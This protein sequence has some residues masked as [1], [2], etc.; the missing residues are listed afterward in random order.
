MDIS[1]NSPSKASKVIVDWVWYEG[2]DALFEGEAVCFNT[3]YGTATARDGRRHNR[4]ERPSQGNNRAFAGVVARNYSAKTNGQFIEIN[5]PGSRGV[6]VALGVDTVIN[7]GFL[8]FQ[9]GGGTGAGRFVKA[10]LRGR[11]SIVP[12]QTKTAV[13]EA[14]MTGA[15]SL[16]TDGKTL[17]VVATAG[18][19]AGDT[20][21]FLGGEIE[22]GGG[23]IVPGKY[24]VAS[25]TNATV[26]VLATSAITGT[27]TGALTC[28]GYAYT[29][30]P[31]CQAD[32][33]EGEESGGVE[34]LSPPNAGGDMT[35]MVGG[36]SYVC[37]GV[38]CA[39]DANIP[40]AAGT[41]PGEIKAVKLLG[42]LTTSDL[43]ITPAAA[44]IQR[45]G[46]SALAVVNAMDAAGDN[47][48]LQFN[49][50]VWHCLDV[51]GG[52]TQA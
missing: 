19:S 35:A 8:T 24:T 45:D 38:T 36:V 32:L 29:G 39:A 37:G 40:L 23:A 22:D 48:F 3:D 16:A 2:S 11:G 30:N 12:R 6:N 1:S 52:T 9:V 13:L 17:T 50:A 5:C 21:V 14:G 46:S 4:V 25:I 7:T 20:V 44:G 41:F 15:W 47:A 27:A 34:F 31:V 49:G 42:T 10:G 43:V 51:A 26:L 18:I 28:T 33:L